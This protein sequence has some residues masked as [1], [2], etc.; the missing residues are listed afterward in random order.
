MYTVRQI[1]G[2]DS[3]LVE[4]PPHIYNC[5]R[6]WGTVIYE[7]DTAIVYQTFDILVSHTADDP[8]NGKCLVINTMTWLLEAHRNKG[9]WEAENSIEINTAFRHWLWPEFGAD[10]MEWYLPEHRV[11]RDYPENF[12]DEIIDIPEEDYPDPDGMKYKKVIFTVEKY[13]E[14]YGADK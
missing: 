8:E 13:R 12:F 2:T 10:R 3:S 6:G 14:L 1:K 7:D 4:H 5:D 9:H 11:T